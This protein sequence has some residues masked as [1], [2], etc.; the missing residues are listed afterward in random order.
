[1]GILLAAVC[2]LCLYLVCVCVR[3]SIEL[4]SL[5]RQLEEVAKGS[6]IELTVNSRRRP[7]L[8][9]CRVLN[10]VLQIRYRDHLLQEQAE[11]QL[12]QNITS[13]AHD[14]RTPLTGA[15][16]YVQMAQECRDTSK[17]AHYL[18]AVEN[19][20]SELEEMLEEMFLYTK[21]TSQDFDLSLEKLQVLPLLSDCL[22]SLYAKFEQAGVTPTVAFETEGLCVMADKEALRR[23]FLNL[24]QNALMHGTGGIS[25]VQKGNQVQFKNTISSTEQLHIDQLFDKF[26]KS[27]PARGKGSSGLGLFIVRELMRKMGGEA[28]ARQEG[29]MLSIILS[30]SEIAKISEFTT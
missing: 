23:V 2:G 28:Q 10:H 15:F 27:D 16:G 12:K 1:M 26:Y 20:L 3:N 14:I 6:H 9:L 22:L 30:F 11:K 29:E 24:I 18:H 5:S 25:I 13:L 21:V 17:R 7:I 4:Y 8:A 19:R